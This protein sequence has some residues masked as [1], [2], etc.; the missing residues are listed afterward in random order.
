MKLLIRRIS[1]SSFSGSE[2]ASSTT[3]SKP[4]KPL[5]LKLSSARK[6]NPV[7]ALRRSVQVGE[8]LSAI[9]KEQGL[10]PREINQ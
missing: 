1:S 9:L 4:A 2:W 10:S 3:S 8:T 5:L 7:K 6:P